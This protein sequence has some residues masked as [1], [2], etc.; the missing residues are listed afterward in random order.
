MKISGSGLVFLLLIWTPS[1][2]FCQTKKDTPKLKPPILTTLWGKESGR[3]INVDEMKTLIENRLIVI[4]KNQQKFD[5]S[6]A[7]IVYR[8]KDMV[9]DE[10]TGEIR[11]RYNSTSYNFR[12]IDTLSKSWKTH[13]RES[14]KSGDQIHIADI[15]VRNKFNEIYRAPD[16]IFYIE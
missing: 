15:I 13:L 3:K 12:N 16:I 2:I 8:S 11:Y 9:Q 7:I 5:I 10:N 6:R 1:F 14:I 4:S